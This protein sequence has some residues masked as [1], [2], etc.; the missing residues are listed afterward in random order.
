[1]SVEA[2][3]RRLLE[4]VDDLPDWAYMKAVE[5]SRAID[6]GDLSPESLAVSLLLLTTALE[7]RIKALEAHQVEQ[8]IWNEWFDFHVEYFG[9]FLPHDPEVWDVGDEDDEE[10]ED[11]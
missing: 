3:T 10:E 6:E 9:S 2:R 1:M 11:D 8:D 5:L 7:R 4:Q